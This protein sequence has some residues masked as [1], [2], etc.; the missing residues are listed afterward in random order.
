[1]VTSGAY[2]TSAVVHI[3]E[4]NILTSKPSFYSAGWDDVDVAYCTAKIDGVVRVMKAESSGGNISYTVYDVLGRKL[5]DGNGVSVLTPSVN[6]SQYM[7]QISPTRV[8][9]VS[10]TSTSVYY[11]IAAPSFEF[12]SEPIIPLQTSLLRGRDSQRQLTPPRV[13]SMTCEIWDEEAHEGSGSGIYYTRPYDSGTQVSLLAEVGDGGYELMFTGLVDTMAY[14]FKQNL[15]T[16]TVNALGMSTRL[17]LNKL[18]TEVFSD[19]SI[20]ACIREVLSSSDWGDD[21]SILDNEFPTLFSYWWLDGVTGWATLLRLINT[22]GPPSIFYE[23]EKG[24]L[25]FRGVGRDRTTVNLEIGLDDFS[26][27]P[28][29]GDVKEKSETEYVV[30]HA[31]LEVLDYVEAEDDDDNI[32]SRNIEFRIQPNAVYD[33]TANFSGPVIS[34]TNTTVPDFESTVSNLSVSFLSGNRG[35]SATRAVMRFDNSGNNSLVKVRRVSLQGRVLEIAS[36]T[37]VSSDGLENNENG[38]DTIEK[39][40]EDH[41]IREWSA[42]VFQTIEPDIGTQLVQSIVSNYHRG[43]DTFYLKVYPRSYLQVYKLLNIDEVTTVTNPSSG[44][45][46]TDNFDTTSFPAERAYVRKIKHTWM[47]GFHSVELELEARSLAFFGVALY[48]LAQSSTDDG[49]GYSA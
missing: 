38:I 41:R 40:I 49:K 28:I 22:Q 46:A 6:F 15:Y 19:V 35:K 31:E 7:Q 23:N 13:P 17:T 1:M 30:N 36:R 45:N 2:S 18:Y 9:Y 37:S 26:Y 25:V 16:Y 27:I 8:W 39:S 3:G 21:F 11:P 32:W 12:K 48:I 4:R 14:K 42:R 47:G 5:V 33:L 29:I 10:S 44:F 34:Y 24:E 20:A 43:V